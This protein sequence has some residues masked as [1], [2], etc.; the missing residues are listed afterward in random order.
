LTGKAEPPKKLGKLAEQAEEQGE[1]PGARDFSAAVRNVSQYMMLDVAK[2]SGERVALPYSYLTAGELQNDGQGLTLLF[3]TH[4]VKVRGRG[5][6]YL[7]ERILTHSLQKIAE[8]D[9][10]LDPSEEHEPFWVKE[11]SFTKTE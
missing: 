2:R 1:R 9:G 8:S 10:S 5:M 11:L 7:Y 4:K 3:A 6:R